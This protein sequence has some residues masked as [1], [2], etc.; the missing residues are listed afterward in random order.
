M[1]TRGWGFKLGEGIIKERL[2]LLAHA[3]NMWVIG[4]I[5]TET[6]IAVDNI[7]E[8][9]EQVCWKLGGEG[10]LLINRHITQRPPPGITEVTWNGA[11]LNIVEGM[12]VLGFRLNSA[13]TE[14]DIRK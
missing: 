4:R 14:T 2:A 11:E 1:K 5:V 8:G 6:R 12:K 3:D 13:G 9:M 10:E 7:V